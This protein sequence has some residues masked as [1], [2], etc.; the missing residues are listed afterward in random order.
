[1]RRIV[2]GLF[3]AL[4]GVAEAPNVW[5]EHFDEDMGE[6]MNAQLDAQDAVLMGRVTY[7]EWVEYWPNSTDEPFA[8][9]INNIP[10]YVVS[11]TLQSVDWNNSTLVNGD[12]T[13]ELTRLK[14]QP[15]K[16]IGVAGSPGLVHSLIQQDLL[17]ELVLMV[18]PVV[19]GKGKKLFQDGDVL[20]RM[21][22]ISSRAS[23][24]GTMILTYQPIKG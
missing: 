1:M 4:D 7:Q 6:A 2:S 17:D 11:T 19:A 10:K 14:Q 22:L 18:H 9:Y 16:N 3:I 21:K 24:T 20:K 5:E 15:G 12:L 23:R 13:E 8:S